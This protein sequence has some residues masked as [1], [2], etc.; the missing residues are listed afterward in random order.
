MSTILRALRRLEEDRRAQV[1]RPLRETVVMSEKMP[2]RFRRGGLRL[3]LGVAAFLGAV[4]F[5]LFPLKENIPWWRHRTEERSAAPP[6]VHEIV[7]VPARAPTLQTPPP[8]AEAPSSV[9]SPALPA[10]PEQVAHDFTMQDPP[11]ILPSVPLEAP[12]P[13]REKKVSARAARPKTEAAPPPDRALNVAAPKP[14]PPLSLE[15][16]V[17]HP[18][19]DRRTAFVRFAGEQETRVLHEGDA[20]GS[21]VL[22]SI[23]PSS[24]VFLDAGKEVRIRL[25][26]TP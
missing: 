5:A 6:N 10:V 11:S 18:V 3:W 24:V 7:S 19:K 14:A 20:L 9:P 16:T 1:E 13:I 8:L 2:G 17:W 15:R 12:A 4:L 22:R 26:S 25:G 21:L 23:E